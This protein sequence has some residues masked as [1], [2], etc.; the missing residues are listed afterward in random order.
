MQYGAALGPV[1]SFQVTNVVEKIMSIAI[2]TKH[3]RMHAEL[4]AQGDIALSR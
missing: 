3:V 4:I 1:L 2:T